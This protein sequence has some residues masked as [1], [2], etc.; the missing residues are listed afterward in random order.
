MRGLIGHPLSHSYSPFI[1][2]QIISKNYDLYDIQ[3]DELKLLLTEKNFECLNVTIPYKQKV[4]PY[5]NELTDISK[6]LGAINCIKNENGNLIGH[7]TDYEGFLWSLH[8][9]NVNLDNGV[10][11][12]LGY[13][14]ASKAIIEAVKTFKN[15]K[16]YIVSSS[17]KKNSI[18]Y[19][20]L[21]KISSEITCIINTTP[22]GMFPNMDD[23][24]IDINKFNN[25][26]VLIDIV[27]NPFRTKLMIDSINKGVKVVG[28]IDMLVA[29]AIKAVEFFEDI[30]IED[31]KI[32]EII[33]KIVNK[34]RNI[35]LIGMPGAG[36]TTIAKSLSKIYNLELIE[37]DYLIEKDI[38]MSIKDYFVLYGE[39]KFREKEK[40]II[41]SLQ[42]KTN[43][44]ISCG[45]G[46]VKNIEN[47]NSLRKNGLIIFLDRDIEKISLSKNRPLTQNK[48]DLIK[49]YEERMSL[50]NNYSDIIIDNN[51][52][53]KKAIEKIKKEIGL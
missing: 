12:V 15:I 38:E 42:D 3:E 21:Y 6:R 47:I 27:Y 4:I 22:V 51:Q 7:N 2:K 48:N 35:V 14:G 29:Q 40:E 53:T 5:L 25:V 18:T 19:E 41:K 44:V 45:G 39:G 16:L 33:K 28:G 43:C 52:T 8:N 26:N 34:K 49:L 36:K 50:Y 31:S 17:N 46:V 30:K 1:H 37:I 20:E 23:S 11:A 32:N 9:N 24:V 13:G 10:I